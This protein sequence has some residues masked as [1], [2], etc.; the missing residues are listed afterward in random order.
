MKIKEGDLVLS[1]WLPPEGGVRL[2]GIV[3]EVLP[4]PNEVSETSSVAR[5]FWINAN[6]TS[7]CEYFEGELELAAKS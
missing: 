5:V 3:T 4:A 2:Q 6:E 1:N 7:I